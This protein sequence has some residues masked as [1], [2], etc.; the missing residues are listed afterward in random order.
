M[1]PP[2]LPI[3]PTCSFTYALFCSSFLHLVDDSLVFESC[4]FCSMICSVVS[5]P[6]PGL[7]LFLLLLH[8]GSQQ[9]LTYVSASDVMIFNCT[10]LITMLIPNCLPTLCHPSVIKRHTFILCPTYASLHP[11]SSHMAGLPGTGVLYARRD[12]G[13]T[14][15]SLGEAFGVSDHFTVLTQ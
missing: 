5:L 13:L 7:S 8:P 15:Q 11:T 2:A 1:L 6:L 14:C 12:C 9:T 10:M 4:A 3:L